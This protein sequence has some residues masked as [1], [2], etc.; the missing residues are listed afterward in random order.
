M[1]IS[2]QYYTFELE[3]ISK[4]LDIIATPPFGKFKKQSPNF[5]EEIMEDI[6]KGIDECDI[7]YIQDVGASNNSWKKHLK[8]FE[9]IL[10][11]LQDSHQP[12]EI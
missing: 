8:T 5:A 3:H 4:D 12:I 10:N 6:L 7:Y 9:C 1:D 2:I 11:H